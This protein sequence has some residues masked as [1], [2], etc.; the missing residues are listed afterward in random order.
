MRYCRKHRRRII[1]KI[2]VWGRRWTV[3]GLIATTGT[4]TTTTSTTHSSFSSI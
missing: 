3:W 2:G 4:G 1:F